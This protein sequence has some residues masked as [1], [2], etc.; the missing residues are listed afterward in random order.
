MLLRLT[1]VLMVALAV[2]AGVA[3]CAENG[4]YRITYDTPR[5]GLYGDR[6]GD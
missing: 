2:M 5:D 3:G 6:S 1:A 4:K